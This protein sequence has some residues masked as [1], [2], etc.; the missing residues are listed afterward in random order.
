[1][2]KNSICFAGDS[3]KIIIP[4]DEIEVF[5]NNFE[6]NTPF[7]DESFFDISK[8]YV[9]SFKWGEKD[10]RNYKEI[11]KSKENAGLNVFGNNLD[12]INKYLEKV[13]ELLKKSQK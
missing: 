13:G 4:Y 9:Y 1:M 7:N 8:K 3:E 11:A 6:L 5:K 10:Y 2:T 12:R